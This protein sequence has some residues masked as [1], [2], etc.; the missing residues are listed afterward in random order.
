MLKNSKTDIKNNIFKQDIIDPECCLLNKYLKTKNSFYE[1]ESTSIVKYY[2]DEHNF[3]TEIILHQYLLNKKITTDF[4]I[5]LKNKKL[6]YIL[7]GK[8]S[9]YNYLETCNHDG[10]LRV[11]S[12]ELF[13]FVNNFKKHD[14]VHGNLHIGNIFINPKKLTLCI[15]DFTHTYLVPCRTNRFDIDNKDLNSLYKLLHKYFTQKGDCKSL[16]YLDNLFFDFKK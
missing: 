15:I 14:L 10:L 11:L 16:L 12:N 2:K 6:R 5:D 1:K 4:D 13:A 7:N 9:L 3:A 8:I